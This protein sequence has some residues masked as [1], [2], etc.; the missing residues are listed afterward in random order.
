MEGRIELIKGPMFAGKSTELMRRMWRYRIHRRCALVKPAS[1]TRYSTLRVST[2]D[3]ISADARVAERLGEA[4]AWADEFDVLLVDE[5]QFFP[6]LAD[7]A[8]GLAD[9]GKTVVVAALS[10]DFRRAPFEQVARLEPLADSVLMLT[11]VCACGRDAPF[12]KRIGARDDDPVVK[13][14]GAETYAACCRVCWAK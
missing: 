7:A 8:G 13:V 9:A 3:K 14:G 4:L 2:H 6:D 5:G 11:A 1:D 12:S 10:G